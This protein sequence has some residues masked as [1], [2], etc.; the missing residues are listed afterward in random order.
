MTLTLFT[1][2]DL[3]GGVELWATDGTSAGTYR[4]KD[5]N[6]SPGTGSNPAN[7]HAPFAVLDGFAYFTANDGTH[8]L[9]IW[10]SDGTAA[11][12]VQVTNLAGA[13][14]FD[15]MEVANGH[16]YFNMSGA[17]YTS[18][19]TPGSTPTLLDANG[20]GNLTVSGDDIYWTNANGLFT[21]DGVHGAQQL[22]NT[23]GY[24]WLVDAGDALYAFTGTSIAKVVGT[25]LTTVTNVPAGMPSSQFD[26]ENFKVIDGTVFF[27]VRDNL[28]FYHSLYS[29]QDGSNTVTTISTGFQDLVLD[30]WSAALGNKLIFQDNSVLWS[31]DGT[32]AGTTALGAITNGGAT[33]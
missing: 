31:S 25:T 23:T 17:L 6:V 22:T 7:F 1:A 2:D 29:I 20:G 14:G 18:T 11:N 28:G 32:A 15:V 12:T 19:G 9:Q 21:D 5:I 33:S 27:A 10:R 30:G 16:L 3:L 4:V 13:S 24:G 26:A 8:G